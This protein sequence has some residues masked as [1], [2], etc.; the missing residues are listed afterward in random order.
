MKTP[1]H[2][3]QAKA[4]AEQGELFERNLT[5]SFPSKDS[6][7]GIAL[8]DL[9]KAAR[10]RQSEW[11][12]VGWRLAAAINELINLGWPIVSMPVHEHGRKRPVAEYSL[13]QWVLTALSG[14]Q[15]AA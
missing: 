7:A 10:L 8:A 11:L 2:D 12:H 9:I 4:G 5:A 6:Q 15:G 3:D 1:A 14:T 13:P